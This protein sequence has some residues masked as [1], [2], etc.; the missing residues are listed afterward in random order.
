M[1]TTSLMLVNLFIPCHCHC[2]Y[3]LLSWD[4]RPVGV[5]YPRADA[6][7]RRM[8]A[9]RQERRPD[10]RFDY[11]F[12]YAM[13]HPRLAEALALL[14]EMGSAEAEYLQ[15]D[16][17]RMR[18]EE[19]LRQ[20]TD[21][22]HRAG[23]KQL[24][25][26]L[27]GLQAYHDD[28]AGRPGDFDLLLRTAEAALGQ[29]QAV[30]A[31]IPLNRE[32][33]GQIDALLALLRGKGLEDIRLFIPHGEGRGAELEP[34]RFRQAD[35]DALPPEARALL[36]HEIY[37]PEREWLAQAAFP[38]EERRM[39]LLSMTP[40]NIEAMEQTPFEDTLARV[41]ALDEAYYAAFPSAEELARLYGD[42][43][44]EKYY[45]LRDLLHFYRRRYQREH[46][47]SLY[48]VTD[49][50]QCGSRRF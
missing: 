1:K 15:M 30:S 32:N 47:L 28:F 39:I 48:D 44:G 20:L 9:W 2:R 23:V 34:V 10:L 19:Q 31:G 26:T 50:R 11:S 13:E 18:T 41:E 29:G 25:F 40:E 5:P 21:D 49:E 27:Y 35:F 43:A 12:G 37:K 14:R 46:G 7:A 42:P 45:R 4:G 16:G 24:N 17:M 36:N 33:A 38:V 22:L 8:H 3:C 6:L